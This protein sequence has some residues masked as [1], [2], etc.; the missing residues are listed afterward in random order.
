MIINVFAILLIICILFNLCFLNKYWFHLKRQW[1]LR[2][3]IKAPNI[4]ELCSYI[5]IVSLIILL[6]TKYW[7]FILLSMICNVIS[8]IVLFP[9]IKSEDKLNIKTIFII[10]IDNLISLYLISNIFI[11]L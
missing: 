3:E 1:S 9:S 5:Y 10:V 11:K 8:F 4:F 7:E 2:N 6:T